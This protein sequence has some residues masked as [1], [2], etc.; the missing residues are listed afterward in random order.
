MRRHLPFAL[1]SILAL[2]LLTINLSSGYLWEDE[3]DTAVL[4]S[5]ILKFG[6]PKAWDG[7]TFIDSDKGARLNDQ[8]VMVSHPW[9][10]YYL[11]AASFAAFGQNNFAARL[12]FAV[13]GFLTILVVYLCV[14]DLTANKWAG[15]CSSAMLAASVQFLLYCRQ[16]RYYSLSMLFGALLVWI[17]FRMRSARACALFIVTA[18]LLFHSHPFGI[19]L[20]GVLGLLSLIYPPFAIQR[21]WFYLAGPVIA[22]FT[23]PWIAFAHG[24][25]AQNS[26]IV[27]SAPQFFGRLIQYLIECVSVT[28]LIGIAILGLIYGARSLLQNGRSDVRPE[29]SSNQFLSREELGLL[30]ICV[31]TLICYAIAIAA[32]ESTDDLWHIGIRYTSAVIPLTAMTAGML[33]IKVSRAR[34]VIWLPLLL[35]FTFTKLPQLTPWIFWGRSVTT[36]DGSEVIEA[37]LP[38]D[39]ADHYVNTGQQMMFVRDLFRQEPGTLGK[40]CQFLQK[41]AKPG[42]VLITNYDWEPLYFYTR[43]PQALK[44]LP[45]YPIYDASRRKGLPDYVFNVDHVHWI[46]WRPVWENYVGYSGEEIERQILS[47]GGRATRV[48]QFEETIWENR[49]E[50]HL[51]RFSADKYFFTAPEHLLPAEIFRIDWPNE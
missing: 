27:T 1:L 41:H 37:H 33:I 12:P 36:L 4:A 45:E 20:V 26:K 25:Y 9:L 42:D 22:M 2:A 11:T 24:G 38:R 48:A 40:I 21:R 10:Q 28:P 6:V 34:I 46:V 7:V 29:Q 30:L 3:A 44:V 18:I 14:N 17:F 51:H 39:V 50:I 19:V 8:L 31:A 16:C 5:N 47:A 15:F 32:T 43:L 35:L 49:P 23:L 13:A